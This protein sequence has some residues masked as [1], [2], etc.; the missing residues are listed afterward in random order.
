MSQRRCPVSSRLPTL[1]TSAV[2][3][4]S[5]VTRSSRRKSLFSGHN[6]AR[7][8]GR[9]TVYT[10]AREVT[11]TSHANHANQ[12]TPAEPAT[13]R[14]GHNRYTRASRDSQPATP[15][16]AYH[17]SPALHPATRHRPGI[18]RTVLASMQRIG[19]VTGGDAASGSGGTLA[20]IGVGPGRHVTD[21]LCYRLV[22]AAHG[23]RMRGSRGG[24]G[25]RPPSP[26]NQ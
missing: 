23:G 26:R 15:G 8:R 3:Y 7:N 24:R 20:A 25:G 17:L 5:S 22:G 13:G 14:V 11:A 12:P 18:H 1:E 21:S 2:D 6:R 19:P 9:L 4:N 16:T 10:F